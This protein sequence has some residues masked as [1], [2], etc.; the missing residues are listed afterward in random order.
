[1]QTRA[2]KRILQG[3]ASRFR[4][5]ATPPIGAREPPPHLWIEVVAPESHAAEADHFLG[6][7]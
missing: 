1:M 4:R 3:H 5:E 6:G 2:F 7:F